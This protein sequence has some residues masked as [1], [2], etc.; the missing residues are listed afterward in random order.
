MLY[1]IYRQ[2]AFVFVSVY[3]KK[4]SIGLMLYLLTQKAYIDNV[5]ITRIVKGV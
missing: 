4:H 5:A 1:G 2:L 3:C